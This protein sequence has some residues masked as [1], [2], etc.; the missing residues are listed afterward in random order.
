MQRELIVK[1]IGLG[2]ASDLTL[3]AP[4]RPGF[5][6]SLDS[7]TYKTRVKRVLATLHGARQ[8][9]H[10]YATARLL[11][12]AVERVGFIHSVRVAVMEPEDKVLL[13]VTF[14]GPWEA[15][16]RVLWDKV[17]AL[18]DLIFCNTDGYVTAW[19]HSFEEWAAWVREVQRETGFFY[20]PPHASAIDTLY[21]RRVQRMRERAPIEH[22]GSLD[23]LRAAM[24]SAEEAVDRLASP[25]RPR[26]PDDPPIERVDMFRMGAEQLR[27]Y[28][29]GLAGLY[30]LTDFYVPLSADGPILRRAAIELLR[31]FVRLRNGRT[32]EV[33]IAQQ[34]ERFQRAL[35]WLF[36]DDT[37]LELVRARP[38]LPPA[39][40]VPP[41]V[42]ADVQGGILRAYESVTHGALLLFS[43]E[44][45][46]AAAG[47]LTA[48]LPGVTHDDHDHNAPPG[49]LYRNIAFTAAGLRAVGLDEDSVALFPEEFQQ[50]MARR[51]GLLGDVRH[52]HPRRWRLPPRFAGVGQAPASEH[53]DLA[54]VHAMV[55]LRCATLDANA[56]ATHD[57]SQAGHPLH[58]E[59]TRLS[60]LHP[61]ARLLAVQSMR[62]RHALRDGAP[63]IAEHFGFVD[64]SGQPDIEWSGRRRK[65]NRVAL[66]EVLWGHQNGVDGAPPAYD[67]RR[68]WLANG[69]F[70]VVRKYRQFVDRL[71][72]A[73]ERAATEMQRRIGG[74]QAR[75][76]ET[77]Y[78][79]LMG[80]RRDG[81][82]LVESEP[83]D[84]ND[85]DYND[86]PQ[87][88]ACPLHS[89]IRRAHPRQASAGGRVPRLVRRGMSYGPAVDPNDPDSA[90]QDRGLVFM[91]YNQSLA[92][93]F[94]VVQRWLTGG[95]STGSSSATS[96]PILGVPENGF[97]RVFRF[98]A[99][100]ASGRSH[101]FSIELE[102][103][104]PLFED[105]A[106]ATQLEWGLYL[107][108]PSV[109][110]LAGLR[111]LAGKT[112]QQGRRAIPWE[113][114]Q[115]LKR[116]QERIDRLLAMGDDKAALEAWKAALE[117]PGA[118]DR[119]V[120]A[121]IWAAI[122]K[123]H[124]GALK[125]PYGTV[126]A[127]REMAHQVFADPDGLYSVSGQRERMQKSFGDTYL[128]L[129][130]GEQYTRESKGMNEAI[131]RLGFDAVFTLAR[132]AAT[133]KIDDIVA[134]ARRSAKV[135]EKRFE[136]VFDARE[137]MDEVVADLSEHWFGVQ[138]NSASLL[139]RGGPDWAWT[140]KRPSLYPGHFTALSRNMFQP[141]PGP[142]PTK[143]GE[144]Y[145]V[146][147]R[148]A[149]RSFVERH[150]AAGT[151][152]RV[153][154]AP[155]VQ[156][157][158]APLA[159]A[160]FAELGNGHDAD[161]VGRLITGVLMGFTPTIIG[162]VLNVLLEWQRSDRF[163]NL[164]SALAGRTDAASAQAVLAGAMHEAA[165][166]R[167]MPQV[168]WRTVTNA[169]QLPTR[170]GGTIDLKE[171]EKVVLG[172]VSG[173][174][175]SLSDG[176]SDGKLM[177]GGDRSK[178]HHPTH[179]CPGYTEGIAAMLGSV[180]GILCR[181]ELLRETA[182]PLS[183]SI[184]GPVD[185][186]AVSLPSR[187]AG[188]GAITTLAAMTAHA[189]LEA[190]SMS[191][192]NISHHTNVP[193][194]G[195]RSGLIMAWGDSWLAYELGDWFPIGTD[196]RDCLLRFGYSVPATF[197]DFKIWGTIRAMAE[198]PSE[199]CAALDRSITPTRKPRAVLLSGGG[200]DST[201][202]TLAKL[203][204][205]KGRSVD[206]LDTAAAAAHVARLRGH[207]V[208]V[209]S[210]IGEV[211]TQ[212]QVEVPVL[213]HGYDHPIPAGQ[214]LVPIQREWLHDA[215]A[216][217]GYAV[218]AGGAD[219]P[220]AAGAMKILITDLNTMLAGLQQ[221]FPFVRH[222][223][224]TGMVAKE[225]PAKPIDGWHDDLHPMNE[226][227]ELMAAKIDAAIS[228]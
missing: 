190:F 63:A 121:G 206:V 77:V 90:D 123:H 108:A 158:V 21:D 198:N 66:G 189:H 48:L 128:G 185:A 32:L 47:F 213:I 14:D 218:G 202:T 54:G 136:T 226:I 168:T 132:D 37:R 210:A 159:K 34:R 127:D 137:V 194:P 139:E 187:A 181:P 13:S 115:E 91:A 216:S 80:R 31:E 163:G 72:A 10:E 22:D 30:R 131:G 53:I 118:I 113:T 23:E 60:A 211:F 124:G 174:Q 74:V 64:G 157:A 27:Q 76:V 143:L 41:A 175:Q 173:T 134:L 18:L 39:F 57:I 223:D 199:F 40:T 93:Q 152:P 33:D 7:M 150:V 156:G 83:G 222:V 6:E 209:L 106:V 100:D 65:A 86:D 182:S 184:E 201:R 117:D 148:A 98:E 15:Y 208:T 170:D 46:Q 164:R 178:T 221:Q 94:E 43:F 44:T 135:G 166:M 130:A 110:A 179:A 171:G 207:Y 169:H 2:S 114:E 105:P 109:S 133:R 125:T 126:I 192:S 140:E 183:Y 51:A 1:G 61:E 12:D 160:A 102:Q 220:A 195:S 99:P 20:G 4:I 69:S 79:K 19:E 191:T 122:R 25:Q 188:G 29:Q 212:A 24:P 96:C 153:P 149:M 62:R 203:L 141:H 219:L 112:A 144:R 16:I 227:F 87:G 97:P 161:F 151:L 75:H 193:K 92:E 101:V 55:Q 56:L 155:G 9:A 217:K 165:C 104:T 176:Q 84:L 205:R 67:L 119:Q 50:G 224:L 68:P 38:A 42:R 107:F 196:L 138:D 59:V 35:D 17:G 85:F 52:N 95:N 111:D 129:D 3:L 71:H 145:G 228:A 73:V 103:R 204:H 49:T 186:A 214:G 154:A 70:L 200:N 177:F 36:P 11:S 197:C 116:A 172:L 82:P 147:L 78:A 146:A 28:L 225:F 142:V 26:V 167:P 215:F 58:A 5:I 120:S 8:T 88:Q 162:A 45:P 89:H 180:V 81:Q